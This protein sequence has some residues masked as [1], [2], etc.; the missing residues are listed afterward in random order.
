MSETNHEE[1][2]LVCEDCGTPFFTAEE[3]AFYESLGYVMPKR[4][5]PCR[6]RVKKVP[7]WE[8]PGSAMPYT[9]EME[10]IYNTICDDWSIEAKKEDV[11]YFYNVEEVNALLDGMSE[12]EQVRRNM[13]YAVIAFYNSIAMCQ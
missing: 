10:R 13:L 7:F 2:L 6:D 12:T 3:K 5:K 1:F 9:E 11:A 4:C 8:D